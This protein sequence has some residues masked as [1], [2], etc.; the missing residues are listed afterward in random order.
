MNFKIFENLADQIE[1][2]PEGSIVSKTIENNDAYKTVIFGFDTGQEL[3]EHQTPM[4]AMI[5]FVSGEMDL[6][7]GGEASGAKPGTWVHMDPSLP[8]SVKAK[9]PAI[10]LL[11]M[12]K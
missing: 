6:S 7:L 8:H 3:S 5:Y 9:E 1:D 10:M 2:I 4:H 12:V 11:V